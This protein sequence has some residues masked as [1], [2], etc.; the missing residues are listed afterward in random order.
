MAGNTKA[1]QRNLE[2]STKELDNYAWL[3]MND[4]YDIYMQTIGKKID[5]ELNRRGTY[6]MKSEEYSQVLEWLGHSY[7]PREITQFL[8]EKRSK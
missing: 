4:S 2:K 6:R 8:I 1:E 5:A 3:Y 7:T